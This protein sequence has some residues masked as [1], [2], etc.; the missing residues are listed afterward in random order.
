MRIDKRFLFKVA[1]YML[2]KP[3]PKKDEKSFDDD[4]VESFNELDFITGG[5]KCC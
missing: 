5:F 4:R 2:P 3:T 1:D